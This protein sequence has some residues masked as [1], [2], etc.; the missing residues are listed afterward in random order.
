[1]D[2]QTVCQPISGRLCATLHLVKGMFFDAS[3][4]DAQV[5]P[6]TYVMMPYVR[7][8]DPNGAQQ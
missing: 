1:M 6:G 7:Q 8:A 5:S 3:S 4:T 2:K